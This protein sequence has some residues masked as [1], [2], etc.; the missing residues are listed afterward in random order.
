M[1]EQSG[2]TEYSGLD[3]LLAIEKSMPNY[4]KFIV[5]KFTKLLKNP[6]NLT[7]VDF[8]AGIGTLSRIIHELS[9]QDPLCVEIDKINRCYLKERGFQIFNMC[10]DI[11]EEIDAIF[12]SNVL[13]HIE[14]D[15]AILKSF[16]KNLN[17][18]GILFLYL[19]AFNFLFSGLDKKVGHFRRYDKKSLKEK[20]KSCGFDVKHFE[21]ADS[22]GF[23]DSIAM[24][25]FGYNEEL[26]L[27]SQKSLVFY[28]KYILPISKFAD[29]LGFKYIFG[30]NILITAQKM[31]D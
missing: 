30:K 21:Y 19:P 15:V 31:P 12:S 3:E 24:K 23:F 25:I 18:N 13:E 7:I 11:P 20:M 28:D 29:S 9:G 1:T 14:D 22:F 8:G 6:D 16:Y 4:N 27:G 26:G 10:D 5:S 2:F 17:E